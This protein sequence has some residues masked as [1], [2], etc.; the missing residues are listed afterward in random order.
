[1]SHELLNFFKKTY[2]NDSDCV[3]IF[4]RSLALIWHNEKPA[5]FS[6]SCDLPKLLHFPEDTFPQSGDYTFYTQEVLYEYHL[7]NAD[8]KYFIV[9]CGTAPVLHKILAQKNIRNRLENQLAKYRQETCGITSSVEQL[10]DLIEEAECPELTRHALYECLN[11]IAGNCSRM[12]R[13]YYMLLE[14]MH[15]YES[16]IRD[17]ELLDCAAVLEQFQKKCNS[18]LGEKSGICVLVHA[19]PDLTIVASQSSFEFCL[20]CILQI[21]CKSN[22]DCQLV[23]MDAR[24]IGD[25][26]SIT[27]TSNLVGEHENT[28]HL[29]SH[30]APLHAAPAFEKELMIVQ[31][32][33]DAYN[34]SFMKSVWGERTTFCLRMPISDISAGMSLQTPVS[35]M[36]HGIM[37]PYYAMLSELSDLR[38]Y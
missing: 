19:Q 20:L 13:E 9:S 5:P 16:D 7:V 12:N 11:I 34:A 25:E 38:Y 37:S 10:N 15:A 1:M 33:L 3:L 6:L 35:S 18:I 31:Q 23:R 8:D 2:Q 29:L 14:I 32:F 4:D 36:P 28:E 17:P 22:S 27:F 21:L 24:Q 26:V 30:F